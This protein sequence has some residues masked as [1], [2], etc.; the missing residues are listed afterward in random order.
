MNNN[1]AVEILS[2]I[3]KVYRQFT[4]KEIEALDMAIKALEY[5]YEDWAEYEEYCKRKE[6]EE[7]EC[8]KH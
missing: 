7:E 5:M 8:T 6:S 4:E 2:N 1:E 3:D